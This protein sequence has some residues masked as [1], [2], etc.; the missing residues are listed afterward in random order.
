M[1]NNDEYRELVNTPEAQKLMGGWVELPQTGSL[2]DFPISALPLIGRDM[3][4]AVAEA[5]Q[6]PAGMAAC[7]LL[8]AISTATVGRASVL[9]REGYSEPIQLYIAVSAM[10]S[11][12]KSACLAAMFEPL[13]AFINEEN[14]HRAAEVIESSALHAMLEKQ[15]QKAQM[16]GDADEVRRLS[17]EIADFQDVQP[18]ELML[19]EATTEALAARMAQNN[20]RLAIVSG[21]GGLLNILA[22]IYSQSGVNLD[23]ILHGYSGEPVYSA[24]IGRATPKIEKAA[25]SITLAVQPAILQAFISNETL[26]G[27][28]AVARFLLAAPPSMLGFRKIEGNPVQKH[29]AA[30]YSKRITE[31]LQAQEII[32]NLSTEA[33]EVYNE[34]VGAIE[35]RLAARG[36]LR[37]VGAGWAGKLCGNTA[38]IAGLLALLADEGM[39]ISAERMQAAITIAQYF[40]AQML[41]LTGADMGISQNAVEVIRYL[42]ELQAKEFS[43]S[44]VR[45]KLRNRKRFER[46]DVVDAALIELAENGYLRLGLQPDWNGVGRPPEAQYMMHPALLVRNAAEVIEI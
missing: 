16:K 23:V 20:G 32:L 2:P 33:L 14:T 7:F 37:D 41:A 21:E 38:R 40:T 18:V 45:R 35:L 44:I 24:R 19:S 28:G 1:Q 46:G 25:L 10:P 34:W 11:E 3:A 27:C 6:V 43:P 26:L 4:A 12:R 8:G 31:L 42:K 30:R 9:V 15:L 13:H 22:G 36:D 29:I 5:V 39:T 17:H